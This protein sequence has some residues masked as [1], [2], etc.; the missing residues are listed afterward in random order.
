[1]PELP[2]PRATPSPSR[3]AANL[4]R[5]SQRTA[6]GLPMPVM[7]GESEWRLRRHERRV[8]QVQ[9]AR[10]HTDNWA[11]LRPW[12][13]EK[14]AARKRGETALLRQIKA[15][16]VRNAS[17]PKT[18]QFWRDEFDKPGRLDRAEVDPAAIESRRSATGLT[19]PISL[20]VPPPLHLDGGAHNLAGGGAT[21]DGLTLS[22][23][24][25]Y[26]GGELS[27]MKLSAHQLQHRRVG[28]LE[29]AA[30]TFC[31][32]E[33]G[34]PHEAAALSRL[35]RT[36]LATAAAAEAAAW[37]SWAHGGVSPMDG[38][39]EGVPPP[40]GRVLRAAL[41]ALQAAAMSCALESAEQQR[42]PRPTSAAMFGKAEGKTINR[43]LRLAAAT[44]A[45]AGVV[46]GWV[47]PRRRR[48]GA[49]RRAAAAE[50]GQ[51]AWVLEELGPRVEGNRWSL[52]AD[53]L[54]AGSWM[55]CRGRAATANGFGPWGDAVL[56]QT[57]PAAPS[58]PTV[59]AAG[60]G[61]QDDGGMPYGAAVE[62]GLCVSEM[63]GA[64]VDDWELEVTLQ[65]SVFGEHSGDPASVAR[66]VAAA[67]ADREDH[68][69][70]HQHMP[71]EEE[72]EEGS[73]VA[74]EWKLTGGSRP[75]RLTMR[76]QLVEFRRHIV[77]PARSCGKSLVGRLDVTDLLPAEVKRRTF[78]IWLDVIRDL[79]LANQEV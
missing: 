28:G 73:P 61:E 2:P 71:E 14:D 26:T 30:A 60:P 6:E 32:A 15:E 58:P 51:A 41:W 5:S 59:L 13:A 19:E 43:E 3:S 27:G 46:P 49:R 75:V 69:A 35:D 57:A 34:D 12:L 24:G 29:S 31:L 21:A 23:A 47:F 36:M 1:M 11:R 62:W 72:E 9:F 70:H 7:T 52:Q 39:T 64:A 48:R 40:S 4:S 78:S 17:G 22:W 66:A 44:A 77:E 76:P 56:L 74:I 53:G 33:R 50:R 55:E 67:T 45:M 68:A 37:L 65:S 54:S 16:S 79:P 20:R 10:R 25:P 18:S 8:S 63:G 42:Q 38:E